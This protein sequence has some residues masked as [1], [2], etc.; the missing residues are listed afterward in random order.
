MEFENKIVIATAFATHRVNGGYFP[1]TR[2]FSEGTATLFSNKEMMA[3]NLASEDDK[4]VPPDF[5]K[6]TVT[7]EDY[8]Q[9]ELGVAFLMKENA[10]QIIA[11]TLTDFMK[12]MLALAK[13][14]MIPRDSFGIVCLIPKIYNEKSK[15]KFLKK[16]MKEKYSHSRHLGAIGDRL[17][18]Q[19]VFVTDVK[20]VEKFGCHAINGVIENNLISFFKEFEQGKPLPQADTKLK[21]NAKVK[22]HSENWITKMPETQLNYVKILNKL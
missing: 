11:G 9:A 3:F 18:D 7:D 17:F 22:R 15:T 16:D 10:L 13:S 6:F 4:M 12:N 20:F 14:D 8:K 19:E 1:D 2:R 21:I 5:T